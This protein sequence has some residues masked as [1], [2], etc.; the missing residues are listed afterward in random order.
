MYLNKYICK[1]FQEAFN[2]S[3]TDENGLYA[4]DNISMN[5]ILNETYCCL[6]QI[7][8][9]FHILIPLDYESVLI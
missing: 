6:I 7:A 8:F 5:I 2:I 4:G 1:R 3:R 9:N